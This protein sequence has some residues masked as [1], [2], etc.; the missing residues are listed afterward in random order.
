[1]VLS[2]WPIM[3]QVKAEKSAEGVHPE[4]AK[5]DLNLGG[6]YGER[7]G[8]HT[9]YTMVTRDE[10]GRGRPRQAVSVSKTETEDSR[11]TCTQGDLRICR[12]GGGNGD[13]TCFK[14]CRRRGWRKNGCWWRGVGRPHLWLANRRG[15]ASPATLPYEGRAALGT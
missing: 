2:N 5:K 1:M 12:E 10:K 4:V 6:W 3:K 8:A 14:S 9:G 11:Y 13:H 15:K 7:G